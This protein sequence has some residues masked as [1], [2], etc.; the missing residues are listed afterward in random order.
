MRK[1]ANPQARQPAQIQDRER[2]RAA[3]FLIAR[4]DRT[5][6][7]NALIQNISQRAVDRLDVYVRRRIVRRAI[8][9]YYRRE[10]RLDVGEFLSYRRRPTAIFDLTLWLL[11]KKKTYKALAPKTKSLQKTW[12]WVSFAMKILKLLITKGIFILIKWGL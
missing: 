6:R 12:F 7:N 1:C 11:C 9:N 5:L 2:L 10:E 8:K 3:W 4:G